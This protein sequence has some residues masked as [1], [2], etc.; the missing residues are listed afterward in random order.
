MGAPRIWW[1][2]CPQTD[3]LTTWWSWLICVSWVRVAFL[4][5]CLF[6]Q[7]LSGFPMNTVIS[8]I[9][10]TQA[11]FYCLQPRIWVMQPNTQE[12]RPKLLFFTWVT[13]TAS[14]LCT[15]CSFCLKGFVCTYSLDSLPDFLRALLE[16]H[17]CRSHQGGFFSSLHRKQFP[18]LYSLSGPFSS[19]HCSSLAFTSTQ[20]IYYYLLTSMAFKLPDS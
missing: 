5:S 13:A 2:W 3:V 11:S 9:V 15:C 20:D 17:L 1:L 10:L 18:P 14:G 4:P 6:F 12:I 19:F 7:P 8:D 16:S